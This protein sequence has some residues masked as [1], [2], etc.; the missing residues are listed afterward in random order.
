MNTSVARE[1]HVAVTGGRIWYDFRGSDNRGCG[2]RSA[3]K[4]SALSIQQWRSGRGRRHFEEA[5]S[6]DHGLMR[7]CG[8]ARISRARGARRSRG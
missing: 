8:L 5:P 2:A 3:G 6:V 4:R 1:G 7:N